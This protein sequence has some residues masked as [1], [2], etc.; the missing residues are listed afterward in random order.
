MIQP[1]RTAVAALFLMSV[2]CL[3]SCNRNWCD[4]FSSPCEV[5]C[6]PKC[7]PC[8]PCPPRCDPCPPRC[9]PCPPSP[10]CEP[11]GLTQGAPS[12]CESPCR[13]DKNQFFPCDPSFYPCGSGQCDQPFPEERC[14][15][16]MRSYQTCDD[17]VV[18][19]CQRA[20]E[21]ATV[22]SPYP[23]EICITAQKT[24]ADVVV[25]QTLPCD[26][27]F[28][29]SDPPAQVDQNN[30]LRWEFPHMKCGETQ[31]ITVWVRPMK[32]GC[33]LA[34]ATV[35]ACPQLCAYTNCGQPV[36][37]IKKYGPECACLYCP[38]SYTIEVCN[39]GSATAYDVVV[40]D[41]VPDGLSHSSGL[42][43]LTYELGD[44]CCGDSRSFCVDFCATK[45]GCVT[46]VATVSYCGGPRCSAE[47]TTLI[48]EPCVQVTKTGPD[49][50]YICKKVDYTITVTNPGDL[51]LRD[52]IVDDVSPAGTTVVDAP[53][54]E[55]CCNRAIWC[56]PEFCPGETKTF[57]VSLQSQV[58]GC[59][60]N[61]VTVSTNSD[62]GQCVSCAEA[63][64]CWKGVPA[65][66]MCMVDTQDPICIDGDSS[67]VYKVCVSNRG[68]AEDTNVRLVLRFTDELKPESANGPTKGTVSGQTVTFEPI[69]KLDPKQCMEYCVR[70][71]AV[72][73]GDARAEATLSSD[74]L[75]TPVTD[76]EA[77]HVY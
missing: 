69:E 66:H 46:N 38:V 57:T 17:C 67:T 55:I 75:G 56:I 44:L 47:A 23:V 48:N 65:T 74:G 6:P 28:I 24:C 14:F 58:T 27:E 59:L 43:C 70:V 63:T 42:N 73:V 40:Q 18:D 7:D 26:S 29:K 4:C 71:R 62:C 45:R 21:F 11:V 37:C 8:S 50:A 76:T 20:P 16:N 15:G 36:V 19:L 5:Q 49:W 31:N 41:A 10:K 77:T 25:N 32:E 64:T 34:A 1:L 22:G 53:G 61:K 54:A 52:V 60:T 13:T 9:D 3:A 39:S 30:S 72:S 35:C 12:S 51:V 33:C 68:S 2:F